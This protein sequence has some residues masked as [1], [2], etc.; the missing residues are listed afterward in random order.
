MLSVP[1]RFSFVVLFCRS[2]QKICGIKPRYTATQYRPTI[3][4]H[5][6]LPLQ[7]AVNKQWRHTGVWLHTA[8]KLSPFSYKKPCVYPV[9]RF[10]D[11]YPVSAVHWPSPRF[12][13]YF[14]HL[15]CNGARVPLQS[16]QRRTEGGFNP[17]PPE[18][19]KFWQSWAEF[20]VPW[21]IHP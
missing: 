2:I 15:F 20:P 10:Q 19:P 16:I 17:P 11:T 9:I 12:S 4:Q 14:H 7:V 21:K 1:V 13:D 3:M 6:H 18:I 8:S 5:F